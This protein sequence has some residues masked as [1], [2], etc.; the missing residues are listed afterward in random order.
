MRVLA[1]ALAVLCLA[2]PA[3]AAPH[4]T[5][6]SLEV[7]ESVWGDAPCA[8]VTVKRTLN[9]NDLSAGWA[10]NTSLDTTAARAAGTVCEIVVNLRPEYRHWF[11][12]YRHLCTLVVHERGHIQGR[13][14]SANPEQ[15]MNSS[16]PFTHVYPACER[17]DGG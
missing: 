14:H 13:A 9:M 2:A 17:Y 7:A 12:Q 8:P 6:R 16:Y 5:Q 11:S 1:T 10:F 4:R 3:Y 15:V